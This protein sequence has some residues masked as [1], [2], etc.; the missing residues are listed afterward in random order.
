MSHWAEHELGGKVV[1]I[2]GAVH[3]NNDVH[4]FGRPFVSA[5]QL[6]IELQLRHPDTV[7]AIGKPIGGAG[8]G[9][10]NSL[11]QYLSNELSKQI[12]AQG[13]AHPVEGAFFSNE[14]VRDIGF[15]GP[16]NTTVTSSL[17]GTDF[18][19]ALFRLRQR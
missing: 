1:E 12:K 19:M 14:K 13:D 8:V 9:Q 16:D 15:K 10:H 3:C 18:D 4:H 2:L 5:Y 6:A 17:T 11:A 7:T